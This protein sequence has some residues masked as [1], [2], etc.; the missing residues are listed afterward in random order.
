MTVTGPPQA[1]AP[2]SRPTCAFCG[3][4]IARGGQT[5]TDAPTDRFCSTA[6]RTAYED[7]EEPFAGQHGYKRAH[8]GVRVLDQVLPEGLRTDALVLL[9]GWDGT[10]LAELRTELAWRALRRD[11][12]AVVVTYADPPTAAIER[13]LA[14]GWNVLPYLESGDLHLIDCFTERLADPASFGDTRNRWNRYLHGV[15]EDA[16]TTANNPDDLRE[17]DQRVSSVVE[18]HAMG[19]GGVITID[20]LDELGTLVPGS[21]VENFLKEIRAEVAKNRY[22]PIVASRRSDRQPGQTGQTGQQP[23]QVGGGL[24]TELAYVA[25][26]IVDLR[27][28]PQLVAD[29][30]IKQLLVRRMDGVRHVPQWLAY[31]LGVDGLAPFDPQT[32][33]PAVYGDGQSAGHGGQS[34]GPGSQRPLQ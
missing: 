22:V 31:E 18:D 12:Q 9:R 24:T 4:R 23:Q 16:T 3:Y 7:G 17:L 29:T 21:Q 5:A 6:C 26:G 25:D 19:P 30:Y 32:E 15:L 14:L 34:A 20:S 11:E 2:A 10:R 28:N 1:Q 33:T 8:T 13:F 27:L